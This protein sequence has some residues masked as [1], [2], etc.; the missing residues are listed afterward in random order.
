MRLATYTIYGRHKWQEFPSTDMYV[1]R[2]LDLTNI[3]DYPFK[4]RLGVG[5][6]LALALRRSGCDC[7][8]HF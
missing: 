8:L 2:T 1:N 3:Q 5:R 6:C 7:F 4:V